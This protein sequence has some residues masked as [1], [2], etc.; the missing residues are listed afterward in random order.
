M[1]ATHLSRMH[2]MMRLSP[3]TL[4][5]LL[6]TALTGPGAR[7]QSTTP[8]D[9]TFL[10]VE[11][12]P[13]ADSLFRRNPQWLGADGA[14]SVDLGEGRVLWLFGDSFISQH[15]T[16]RRAGSRMVRNSVGVQHGY[17]PE[18]A[19]MRFYWGYR[20][21]VPA[22]FFPEADSTWFWPGHGARVGDS[23]IVFLFRLRKSTDP[24]GFEPSGWTAVMIGN[25]DDEPLRWRKR[26]LDTP[27]NPWGIIVGNACV[28]AHD[29]WLYAYASEEPGIHNI[30]LV[31]WPLELAA[32]GNLK[33]PLWWSDSAWVPQ[34]RLAQKPTPVFRRGMSEFT[35]HREPGVDGYLQI[36]SVGFGAST[37]GYRVAP[38]LTGP[39]PDV[40]SFYRPADSDRPN[41]FVYAGKAHAAL[42]GADLVL[43]YVANSFDIN[44][45]LGDMSI[46]FPRFLKARFLPQPR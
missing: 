44:E 20:N 43:T 14:Y 15:G 36:Q 30:Y 13:G 18:S 7:A 25:P 31:R 19:T 5:L 12:W 35:V 39:W 10:Q 28:R 1:H 2:R 17:N 22:S 37:I 26:T 42:E 21:N 33:D 9:S 4:L 46:Y 8:L 38:T 40:T 32:T 29:G 11:P 16:R 27:P 6:G 23:L 34:S 41:P 24:L 45:V 3:G